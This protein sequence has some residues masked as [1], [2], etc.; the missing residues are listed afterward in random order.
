MNGIEA[1]DDICKRIGYAELN[2][3][4]IVADNYFDE[5]TAIKTELKVNQ[6]LKKKKVDLDRVRALLKQVEKVDLVLEYYNAPY[7]Y[8]PDKCYNDKTRV[9]TLEEITSIIDWIKREEY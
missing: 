7:L 9:L 2:Y 4:N 5:I 6:I 3:G 8:H 1:L